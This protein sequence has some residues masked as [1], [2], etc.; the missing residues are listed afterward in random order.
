MSGMMRERRKRGEPLTSANEQGVDASVPSWDGAAHS[1]GGH[2]VL[3]TGPREVPI[4][5]TTVT[6]SGQFYRCSGCGEERV[7]LDQLD[8]SRRAAADALTATEGLLRPEEIRALREDLGLSQAAFEKALGLGPKTMVRWETGK[9]MPSQSMALLLLLIRRDPSAMG[10]L[11]TRE[12][13]GTQPEKI[14]LVKI[15]VINPSTWQ[16][17][18]DRPLID[19]KRTGEYPMATAA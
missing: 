5:G 8:R 3:T 6:V 13:V 11:M 16:L 19:M 14:S 1:C 12:N 4:R 9:V 17:S 18:D 15:Q 2:F 7:D 10:F